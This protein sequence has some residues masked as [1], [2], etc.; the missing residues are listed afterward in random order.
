MMAIAFS[1]CITRNGQGWMTFVADR[2]Q[3]AR[4]GSGFAIDVPVTTGP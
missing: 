2:L 3:R 1:Q 4:A